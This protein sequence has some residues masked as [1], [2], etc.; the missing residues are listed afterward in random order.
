[1]REEILELD[2]RFQPYLQGKDYT[3]VGPVDTSLFKPFFLKV[4]DFAPGPLFDGTLH[5]QLSNKEAVAK[6]LDYLPNN[7]PLRVYV[8]LREGIG[9]SA[10][11]VHASIEIYCRDKG[12]D[13]KANDSDGAEG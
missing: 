12:I 6:A 10:D 13:F 7:T 1:M 5:H 4:G 8:V 11:L 2:N 3:F 9:R